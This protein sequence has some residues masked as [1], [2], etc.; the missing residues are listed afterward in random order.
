MKF[1][2]EGREANHVNILSEEHSQQR[3]MH[4]DTL[5]LESGLVIFEE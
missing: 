1:L 3:Q 2:D 4:D 5:R